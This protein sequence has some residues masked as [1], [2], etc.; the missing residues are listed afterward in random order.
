MAFI[1]DAEHL[2]PWGGV[3]VGQIN[4]VHIT[5]TG[6]IAT[7]PPEMPERWCPLQHPLCSLSP[8]PPATPR[9]SSI[10]HLIPVL[11]A[12]PEPGSLTTSGE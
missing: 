8:H 5:C 12:S 11:P 4:P 6:A 1:Y 7:Q 3:R 10:L 2:G 9:H